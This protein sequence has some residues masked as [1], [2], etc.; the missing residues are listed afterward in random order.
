VARQVLAG[1]RECEITEQVNGK[2]QRSSDPLKI[3][4]LKFGVKK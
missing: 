3:T 2:M 4:I 1:R